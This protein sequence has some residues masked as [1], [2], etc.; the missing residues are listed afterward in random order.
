MKIASILA[1]VGLLSLATLSNAS[2]E[3]NSEFIKGFEQGIQIGE[4]GDIKEFGCPQPHLAGPL[5][6]L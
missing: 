4:S 3:I 6:N 5:G 2:M 1:T